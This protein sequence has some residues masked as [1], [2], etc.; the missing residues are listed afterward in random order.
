LPATNKLILGTVQFGL[1]YGINNSAGKPTDKELHAILELAHDSGIRILDSAEAYGDAIERI[2]NYHGTSG[3]HFEVISRYGASRSD[4]PAGIRDRISWNLRLLQVDSLYAYMY[5]SYIDYE[6]LHPKLGKDLRDLKKSGV[7]R[8][9]GVSVYTG[10]EADAL[11]G[12]PDIDVI[13]LPLNLLDNLSQKRNILEKA[14][15]WG[16]ELHTRSAYLQGLFFAR[17]NGLQGKLRLLQPYLAKL[18]AIAARSA[19]SIGALALGYPVQSGMADRVV[20]GV[21][22]ADQLRENLKDVSAQLPRNAIEEIEAIV[23]KE[24]RLLDP[25]SWK[26]PF[27]VAITQARTS[28]SRLPGKVLK[29]ISGKTLLEVHLDRILKSKSIDKLLLAT[30]EDQGDDVLPEIA[31]RTSVDTFRGSLTDVLDRFYRAASPLS[32]DWV[33]RLTA[34][35]PLIDPVLIDQ[36][37]ERAIVSGADYCSNNLEPSFPDGQDIEVFRFSALEAAFREAILKSD[38]EHV[39]PFIYRNARAKGGDRFTAVNFGN[40]SDYS[41]VRLTVDEPEDLE[42]VRILAAK[43]GLDQG[44]KEYADLYG[45]D[46]EIKKLNSRFMR[47]EGYEKSKQND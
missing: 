4:L 8:R 30:S 2:G 45:S 35:C 16:V 1:E 14:K 32:P 10:D 21:E 40:E 7:I 43:L 18:H 41:A 26:K 38:R 36:V 22:S 34:D 3:K 11:I 46:A 33:V 15:K 6:R 27:V 19:T 12:A 24:K 37:V 13:Q 9:I 42:V 5:H 17:E 44:W 28:S 31:M 20:I 29:Q 23:V 47:N 25:S 39:T